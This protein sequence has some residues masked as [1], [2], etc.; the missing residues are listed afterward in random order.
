[1]NLRQ[2][3]SSV[4]IFRIALCVIAVIYGIFSYLT[5]YQYEDY[6]L[7]G[8][9]LSYNGGD[10]GFDWGAY[11][12][13]YREMREL[14]N[15]RLANILDLMVVLCMP[16]WIFAILTG[17]ATAGMFCFLTVFIRR[18]QP[19]TS[20][21]AVLAIL[22]A[23]SM[24]AFPWR[25]N[26]LVPDYSLNYIFASF[27]NLWFLRIITSVRHEHNLTDLIGGCTAALIAGAFHEGFSIPVTLGL[28]G[29]AIL[30]RNTLNPSWW[31]LLTVYIS[32]TAFIMTSPG[33]WLRANREIA[34]I[35]PYGWQHILLFIVPLA[36]IALV[37]T[38][39]AY[40][41]PSIKRRI[42]YLLHS[43]IFIV[44][45]TA[46]TVSMA[47]CLLL[48]ANPRNGWLPEIMAAIV[49]GSLCI[50][51]I[52]PRI[53]N[54]T[55]TAIASAI[56]FIATCIF[57]ANV[58]K[59]QYFFF[60]QDQE[61]HALISESPD[62]TVYYD[63]YPPEQLPLTALFQPAHATW[64]HSFQMAALN[65]GAHKHPFISVVPT[66]LRDFRLEGA[67]PIDGIPGL[68]IHRGILVDTNGYEDCYDVI[69][70]NRQRNVTG[71]MNITTSK[72]ETYTTFI[73]G[74]RFIS[75]EG[76][77]LFYLRPSTQPQGNIITA[78]WT[79]R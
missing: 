4:T 70:D 9:Y 5:P 7:L 25:D 39:C 60:R 17:L 76:D 51:F 44:S 38:L 15:G 36:S 16:K 13:M 23:V 62:G 41:I 53:T 12:D 57:M 64:T 24:V 71:Y 3:I 45:L 79:Q 78:T 55:A 47:M 19:R 49:L 1:M 69:T 27:F 59:W 50:R 43:Q 46:M 22:W 72:G 54:S 33:I 63:V 75:A 11:L 20:Q 31:I 66:A 18:S 37:T 28:L 14:D 10:Y 34:T 21:F 73:D 65:Q 40:L 29:Y 30:H 61:I 67:Q 2:Q 52:P 8:G 74:F 48:H 6:A 35:S 56:I 68:Y 42:G 58:L 32:G 77:T 26:I